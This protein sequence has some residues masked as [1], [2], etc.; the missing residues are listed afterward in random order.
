VGCLYQIEFNNGKSYIGI[1]VRTASERFN[2]HKWN[3]LNK[4][5]N[6]TLLHNALRKY[7]P[8][9]YKLKT[10]VMA[11]DWGYLCELEKRAIQIFNTMAPCGYNLTKG[12]EGATGRR[13]SEKT[14]KLIAIKAIGR[15]VTDATRKKNSIRMIGNKH[16]L[17]HKHSDETKQKISVTSKRK[18]KP[19]TEEHKAKLAIA[20]KGKKRVFSDEHRRNL[21]IAKIAVDKRKA[22]N[23]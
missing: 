23:K 8:M 13:V 2:T 7:N 21:S 12:G 17:G 10:L 19:L 14:K 16:L 3:A 22:E 1:T 20:Q 6:E 18:R 15:E 11:E 4:R 5:D 9:Q